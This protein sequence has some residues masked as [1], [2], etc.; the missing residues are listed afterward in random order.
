MDKRYITGTIFLT[1]AVVVAVVFTDT[2]YRDEVTIAKTLQEKEQEF[3]ARQ[4]LIKE[5]DALNKEFSASLKEL[6]RIDKYLPASKNVADLL[7]QLDYMSSRNGLVMQNVN[8]SKPA[9]RTAGSGKYSVIYVKLKVAGSYNSFLN[10]AED[11]KNSIHLMNIVGFQVRAEKV[12]VG[13]DESLGGDRKQE[14][15]LD[16]DLDIEA[17]YQ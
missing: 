3:Q 1:I 10:F 17:Y 4:I 2:K 9:E 14:T 11:V 15:V 16:L 6:E 12:D 8:F 7:L 13:D 5:V